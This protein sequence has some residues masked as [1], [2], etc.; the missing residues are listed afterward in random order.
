M[1]SNFNVL[2]ATCQLHSLM[3]LVILSLVQQ[4]LAASSSSQT[5]PHTF[6]FVQSA[7][8]SPVTSNEGC[9]EW[10]FELA[11]LNRAE[12]NRPIGWPGPGTVL[13]VNG[14]PHKTYSGTTKLTDGKYQ[15]SSQVHWNSC[16]ARF[17]NWFNQLTFF[18]LCPR[19]NGI[20][21]EL[22][23]VGESYG[24]M[25]GANDFSTW[26]GGIGMWCRKQENH[27]QLVIDRQEAVDEARDILLARLGADV[28]SNIDRHL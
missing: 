17:L 24:V 13:S 6:N 1:I 28:V 10:F 8:S 16:S 26:Q 11:Q 20:E 7:V 27:H 19:V 12:C 9:R 5:D 3:K 22:K 23:M 15:C 2:R 18:I 21:T 14:E 4:L 25:Y